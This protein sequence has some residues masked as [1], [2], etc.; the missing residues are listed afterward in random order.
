MIEQLRS[1]L[2]WLKGRMQVT[3]QAHVTVIRLQAN[4]VPSVSSY[5]QV[6]FPFIRAALSVT[7]FSHRRQRC[8]KTQND[9]FKSIIKTK[10]VFLQQL[11]PSLQLKP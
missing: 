3:K 7:E 9:L 6:M 8:K 5:R 11:T 1:V 10:I 4:Q 2:L